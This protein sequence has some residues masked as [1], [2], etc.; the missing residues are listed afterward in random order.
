MEN[1]ISYQEKK[2]KKRKTHTHF[3]AS[4]HG[5]IQVKW[6]VS[7][8]VRKNYYMESKLSKVCTSKTHNSKCS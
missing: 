7:A 6:K 1:Y 8:K 2:E 5:Y 4:V 3:I